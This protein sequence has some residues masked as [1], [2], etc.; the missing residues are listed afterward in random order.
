MPRPTE[1]EIA[2]RDY[3]DAVKWQAAR[4]A[5]EARGEGVGASGMAGIRRLARWPLLIFGVLMV[6]L[7]LQRM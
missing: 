2:Q 5:A 7:F 4:D 6:L 1:E 3:E